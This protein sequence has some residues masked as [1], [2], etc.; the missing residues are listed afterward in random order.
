MNR[1]KMKK[2]KILTLALLTR[3]TEASTSSGDP[4]NSALIK[5]TIADD[6]YVILGNKYVQV[7]LAVTLILASTIALF[8][9]LKRSSRK[10]KNK[11]R[12]KNAV[13]V[14]KL[15]G[16]Q[17]M[18]RTNTGMPEDN[19]EDFEE[20][21]TETAGVF[22]FQN[23]AGSVRKPTTFKEQDFANL[24]TGDEYVRLQDSG[25]GSMG[26]KPRLKGLKSPTFN[27]EGQVKF[28][29][30]TLKKTESGTPGGQKGDQEAYLET[31]NNWNNY[32]NN[33]R[34]AHKH[35]PDDTSNFNFPSM[36]TQELEDR[37]NIFNRGQ[38]EAQGSALV[39]PDANTSG[40]IKDIR[41]REQSGNSFLVSRDGLS[42][43]KQVKSGLRSFNPSVL[44]QER[45]TAGPGKGRKLGG[46]PRTQKGT[47]VGKKRQGD[48]RGRLFSQ[49]GYKGNSD[50]LDLDEVPLANQKMQKKT[51]TKEKPYRH[52]FEGD[53]DEDDQDDTIDLNDRSMNIISSVE[54]SKRN[55]KML[56]NPNSEQSEKFASEKNE[57][58]QEIESD[59]RDSSYQPTE[60]EVQ[61]I[62]VSSSEEV[63][64][65]AKNEDLL[66]SEEV[67]QD[68]IDL[69]KSKKNSSTRRKKS[70]ERSVEAKAPTSVYESIPEDQ[71]SKI[72]DYEVGAGG[73]RMGTVRGYGVSRYESV[74]NDEGAW[75]SVAGMSALGDQGNSYWGSRRESVV[76][77]DVKR[78]MI[79]T[80]L[81]E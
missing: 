81:K 19:E 30:I 51:K 36:V 18:G 15:T 74:E 43:G 66:K 47:L 50:T 80:V 78:K 8:V 31:K 70:A 55:T 11:T 6:I 17:M 65:T 37:Q 54:S 60:Q 71:T 35:I 16:D 25:R 20:D 21:R 3:W 76:E 5:K 26:P 33:I 9:L 34:E 73:K 67:S 75:E 58:I 29:Q 38:T 24:T 57:Q 64:K 72:T 40:E 39:N 49:E 2:A 53:D 79:R 45:F 28:S 68:Q 13:R 41:L 56:K 42:G 27:Q 12:Q 22:T 10:Q 1:K 23:D 77:N 59:F 44:K 7:G 32:L 62:G 52:Y 4:Q 69:F 14:T 63:S 61:D 46:Q 48:S